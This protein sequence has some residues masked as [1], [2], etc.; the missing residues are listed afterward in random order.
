MFH[1]DRRDGDIWL[2]SSPGGEIHTSCQC[3]TVEISP[4]S[5][6]VRACVQLHRLNYSVTIS[7]LAFHVPTPQFL[8]CLLYL[9][10]TPR[11]LHGGRWRG[12]SLPFQ[13]SV[14][15]SSPPSL[16]SRPKCFP[17]STSHFFPLTF[18]LPLF[19]VLG[20]QRIL[21]MVK[22]SLVVQRRQWKQGCCQTCDSLT[23]PVC[24]CRVSRRAVFFIFASVC[25]FPPAPIISH[26]LPYYIFSHLFIFVP[27]PYSHPVIVS[28]L[29]GGPGWSLLSDKGG[30]AGPV[31][32]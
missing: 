25:L 10:S 13:S 17:I 26:S 18:C 16:Q 22:L 21:K 32:Q 19:N 30:K 14:L 2:R 31:C 15:Q 1:F 8:F 9:I 28:S 11:H 29:T 27:V 23:H 24:V 4:K 5:A 6:C 7:T 12:G 3:D 20:T